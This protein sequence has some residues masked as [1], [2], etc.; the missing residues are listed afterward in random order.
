M[1]TSNLRTPP[2]TQPQMHYKL[3]PLTNSA[4]PPHHLPRVSLTIPPHPTANYLS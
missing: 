4:N 3:Q 2:T 1:Y